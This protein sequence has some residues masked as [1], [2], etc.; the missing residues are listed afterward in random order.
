[1]FFYSL[2]RQVEGVPQNAVNPVAGEGRSL[3]DGLPRRALEDPA[4]DRGVFAFR[5]LAYDQ[6][7]DIAN[8]PA[9]ERRLDP[10]HEPN[11]PQVYIE[12]KLP[13]HRNQQFPQRDMVRHTGKTARAKE[14]RVMMTNRCESILRHHA[15]VL[16]AIFTAPGKFIPPKSDIEFPSRCFE[17]AHPLGHDLFADPITGDDSYTVRLHADFLFL[18]PFC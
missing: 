2:S 16:R 13:A 12:I 17:H 8:V 15:T 6:E 11:R 14:D 3:H 1:M 7:I 10:R 9:R 5:V 4:A 18:T